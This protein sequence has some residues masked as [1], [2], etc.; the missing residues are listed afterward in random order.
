MHF[1]ATTQFD[2]G[3]DRVT[4]MLA[5]RAFVEAVADATGATSHQVDVAA[6]PDGSFTATT[7]RQMPTTDIPAQ[8][9]SVVGSTLEVL[10]VDA[11]EAPDEEGR[12]GTV[13]VEITGAPVRV[14][15]TLR[16]TSAGGVTTRRAD[17]E[18]KASIPL[19]GAAVESAVADALREAVA[20]EE[21]IAKDWLRGQG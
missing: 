15:G 13:V 16:L 8:F 2:A 10:Q 21:R 20:A 6:D 3:P 11:W 9:R 1:S 18:I 12:R 17:A 14:T 19:F 7:R 4:E 5:D